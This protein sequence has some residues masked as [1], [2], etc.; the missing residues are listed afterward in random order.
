MLKSDTPNNSKRKER[1]KKKYK[2]VSVQD[3]ETAREII[4]MKI[5]AKAQR[6]RRHEKRSKQY[7]Q[8]RLFQNDRKKF[9]RTLGK[10]Q[11]QVEK[12]PKKEEIERFWKE[13]LEDEKSHQYSAEWI[14]RE[15]IKYNGTENQPWEYITKEELEAALRKTNNWKSPG[16]DAVPNFWLKQL[17]AIHDHLVNSF[18]N[19]IEHPDSLPVWFTTAKTY[20]LPKTADTENPKNY[21][22]IACLSTS[23]KVL[24][25][26]ITER[27]YTHIAKNNILPEEQRG[28]VRNSY[29]CKDQLLIN[30]MIIEDCK[31]KKKNLRMAWIDYKKA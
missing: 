17:T 22:P 7:K 13:I 23:Y 28:C 31:R 14:E 29:G 19:A 27:S 8:N 24:T 4:K 20:L 21:R 25:S 12:P 16:I 1:V 11:I 3:I 6:V 5:Q 30:K 26:I 18:N 15:E 9:Y 2:I 10:S